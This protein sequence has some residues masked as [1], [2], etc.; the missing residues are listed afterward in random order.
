MLTTARTAADTAHPASPARDTS[1][2]NA[3]RGHEHAPDM[4]GPL[5]HTLLRLGITNPALLDRG[6]DLD[7]ASQR[8]LIDAADQLPPGHRRPQSATLNKSAASAALLNYA[9]ATIDG[10]AARHIRQPSPPEQKDQE[11]ELEPET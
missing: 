9:L 3:L 2:P 5:Q 1:A 7:D 6:A 11:P 4:P 8:L 10:R